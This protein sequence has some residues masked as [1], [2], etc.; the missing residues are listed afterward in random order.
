[1]LPGDI[2]NK[3]NEYI[4]P[5]YY[6]INKIIGK[7]TTEKLK[8]E[9]FIETAAVSFLRGWNVDNTILVAE[10]IQNLT[11]MEL[12]MILTRIGFNSKFIL[13]GDVEQSDKFKNKDQSG[14]AYA[15]KNLKNINKVGFF[16]FTDEDIVRNPLIS[17]ILK[18]F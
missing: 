11:I 18:R 17:E 14:L 8:N 15:I 10:E 3:I 16:E 13:S 4:V 5:S 6:L 1:M 9:G 12:K 2:V 7:E